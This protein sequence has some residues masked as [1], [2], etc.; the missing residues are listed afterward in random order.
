LGDETW[1][2]GE[3]AGGPVSRPGGDLHD[4]RNGMYLTDTED[5]AWQY[6]KV[7]APQHKDYRVLQLTVDRQTFGRV[8]DLTMDSRWQKFMTEPI[9]PGSTNPNLKKSRLDYLRIKYEL[10]GQYFEEFLRINK[11]DINSYDAVIGHEYVRGGKQLCLLHKNGMPTPLQA[12]IRAL[13][14]PERWAARLAKVAGRW[15]PARTGTPVPRTISYLRAV[16]GTIV[17]V[18]IALFLA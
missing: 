11:I 6:A 16:G 14:R 18:G 5:V 1:F 3:R 8:L 7:R 10:Y 13:L 9:V 17:S 2:R 12:R 4:L 15:T